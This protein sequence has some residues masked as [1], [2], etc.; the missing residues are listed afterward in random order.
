MNRTQ[1]LQLSADLDRVIEL[2]SYDDEDESHLL[3]NTAI[4][5]TGATGI[6]GG[7]YAQGRRVQNAGMRGLSGGALE[8]MREVQQKD[9][10]TGAMKAGWRNVSDNVG[11]I[12][13]NYKLDRALAKGI[14]ANA[15]VD[16][17][18]LGS[19]KEAGKKAWRGIRHLS[20]KTENLLNLSAELDQVINFDLSGVA[21]NIGKA[22]WRGTTGRA[23]LKWGGIG[24]AGGALAGGVSGALS[25]DPNQSAL[26]GA[27]KGA[28]AGGALGAIGGGGMRAAKSYGAMTAGRAANGGRI[29]SKAA[30]AVEAPAASAAAAATPMAAAPSQVAGATTH[31]SAAYP[32]TSVADAL[33]AKKAAAAA[34]AAKAMPA[35]VLP[36][37]ADQASRTAAAYDPS[38]DYKKNPYTY[39]EAERNNTYS[40]R[41]QSLVQLSADLD[42]VVEF[43]V[44][45]FFKEMKA[46]WDAKKKLG[47]A[48]MARDYVRSMPLLA[49]GQAATLGLGLGVGASRLRRGKKETA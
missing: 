7:L 13:G 10:V 4:A 43:G 1:L 44:K 26:G 48:G 34:P 40:S 21:G 23:A 49:T 22:L 42:G 9:G 5:G 3:R 47:A 8:T 41:L 24:A 15:G 27:F 28:V 12:R 20:A 2:R 11:G 35:G 33:A 36:R 37:G 30:T 18:R 31:G 6:A 25:D 16:I 14:P 45:G 39:Q 32:N 19:L 29:L 38:R 17:S 46:G